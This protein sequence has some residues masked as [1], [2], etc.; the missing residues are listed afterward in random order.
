MFPGDRQDRNPIKLEDMLAA[1]REIS[2]AS[3]AIETCQELTFWLKKIYPSY[4]FSVLLNDTGLRR[5]AFVM[6]DGILDEALEAV[7]QFLKEAAIEQVFISGQAKLIPPESES[8]GSRLIV[9]L[10]CRGRVVGVVSVVG[11]SERSSFIAQDVDLI[12]FLAAQAAYAIETIYLYKAEQERLQAEE[13]LIWAERKLS[14]GLKP[15]QLPAAILEQMAEVVAYER[16]SFLMREG[17][18]LRIAAQRGFPQDERTQRLVIPLREGD[19]YFQIAESCRPVVIDDVTQSPGWTQVPWLPLNLSWLGVPLF[20]KNQV[21]GMVSLTRRERGAFSQEDV[22]MATT[23]A[24]QA[25]VA[26]E[27]AALYEEITRFNQQLELM[28]QQRTEELKKALA[29]LERMDKNKTDF[30]NVAAHELRTPLTIMKGYLGMLQANETVKAAPVLT[31]A[32]DGILKGTERLHEIINSMLDVARIDNQVLN[33]KPEA[34][35][36]SSIIKRV[37]SDYSSYLAERKQAMQ[38]VELDHLPLVQGDALML[39]KV[40]QNVVINAI[41]YTPDGGTITITGGRLLDEKIGDC[42]EIKIQDT[43]IGIDPEQ[44]EVIFEKFYS[45]GIV[46]LHSSGKSSFKGGGPGLGLAIARGIVLAHGG[47]IWVESPHCDE[48]GCPGSCFHIL[49][50]MQKR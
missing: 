31:Q 21:V 42:I 25:A 50:P 33:L 28:V 19:V 44:Q 22:L 39:L 8:N 45:T 11:Q 38:L 27:N 13:K 41:K 14:A 5:A 10:E 2:A 30:I 17:Q 3:G 15:V 47:R 43:G 34:V 24:L 18:V 16:G 7:S 9:P 49:L 23:F 1:S 26:L 35:A 29:T 40:F 37:Q 48:E 20:S 36:L 12:S 6:K 46:S 4:Q 32:M